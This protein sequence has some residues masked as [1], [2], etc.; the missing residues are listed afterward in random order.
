MTSTSSL[1]G[2]RV[3]VTGGSR[4]IGAAIVRRHSAGW[5][6]PAEIAVRPKPSADTKSTWGR[7]A[8]TVCWFMTMKNSAA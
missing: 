7:K 2:K 1:A 8:R 4:G 3:L 6:K 5:P